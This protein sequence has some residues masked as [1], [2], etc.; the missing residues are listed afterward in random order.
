MVLRRAVEDHLKEKLPPQL[1][2]SLEKDVA[3]HPRLPR[4]LKAQ[5]TRLKTLKQLARR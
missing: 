4:K 3:V 2:Q 1:L 5:M